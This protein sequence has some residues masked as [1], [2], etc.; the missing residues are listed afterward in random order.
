MK[1]LQN[2]ALFAL[3]IS[4]V[5]FST[6][7]PVGEN[8][9]PVVTDVKTGEILK[10]NDN[11]GKPNP[12]PVSNSNT[13]ETDSSYLEK[14]GKFAH[15]APGVITAPLG[16]IGDTAMYIPRQLELGKRLIKL[17]GSPVAAEGTDVKNG[18]IT[19]AV[20]SFNNHNKIV[21]AALAAAI[22]TYYVLKTIYNRYYGNNKDVEE[23]KGKG[24]NEQPKANSGEKQKLFVELAELETCVATLNKKKS[25]QFTSLKHGINSTN[26]EVK[27]CAKNLFNAI[28]MA[29]TKTINQAVQ[30]YAT[31]IKNMPQDNGYLNIAKKK[32]N[33]AVDI[34][35]GFNVPGADTA[36]GVY[37]YIKK[38]ACEHP[39]LAITTGMATLVTGGYFFGPAA[40]DLV[41]GAYN[42]LPGFSAKDVGEKITIGAGITAVLEGGKAVAKAL[43]G[44]EAVDTPEEK[45]A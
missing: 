14:L 10:G 5:A 17:S 12:N 13:E 36:K 44:D 11:T 40:L 37:N 38:Q 4:T 26:E 25:A 42:C 31:A 16:W 3:L 6:V 7:K 21:G 19:T 45:Q 32:A 28:K 18:W 34:V 33:Q 1:T 9:E 8:P 41:K 39:Y 15:D 29:N 35:K 24:F 30:K 20:N 27:T 2:K 22:P 23:V 43:T